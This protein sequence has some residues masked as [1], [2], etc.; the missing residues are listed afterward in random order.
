M[1]G[2]KAQNEARSSGSSSDATTLIAAGT[3]IHGNVRFRGVMHVE[4]KVT[5]EYPGLMKAP[6][7]WLMVAVL[8]VIFA[9]LILSLTAMSKV[10]FMPRK[11]W[12]WPA[13]PISAVMFIT[14]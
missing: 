1:F 4:G 6:C 10:M 2:K 8:K 7:A 14:S 3:E 12:S 13:M 11:N 9:R 5:G